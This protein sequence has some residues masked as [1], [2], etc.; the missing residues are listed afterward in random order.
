M[1][2]RLRS[3]SV[4]MTP[5]FADVDPER[6]CDPWLYFNASREL[7]QRETGDPDFIDLD[8]RLLARQGSMARTVLD[9]PSFC[10]RAPAW[11]GWSPTD[12]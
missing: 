4:E 5:S 6:A 11:R 1:L 12:G 8:V 7:C 2:A 9:I 10:A 3:G